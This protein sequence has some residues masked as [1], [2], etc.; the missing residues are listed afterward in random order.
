QVCRCRCLRLIRYGPSPC[1]T[2]GSWETLSEYPP[3]RKIISG[4]FIV[5]A[6]WNPREST[7]LQIPQ[8]LSAALRLRPFSNSTRQETSFIIGVE[9]DKVMSGPTPT[10][11]SL[12]TT[13]VMSGLA[14][15]VGELLL[16]ARPQERGGHVVRRRALPRMKVRCRASRAISTTA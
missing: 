8:R 12:S 14:E 10:M 11:A 2:T 15:T 6:L 5:G 4:S 16:A 9:V 3:T 7:P 1:R 13:K